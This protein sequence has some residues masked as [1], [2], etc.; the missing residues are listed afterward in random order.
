MLALVRKTEDC[1]LWQGRINDSG[2]GTYGKDLAHRALYVELV[3]PI[4][5][6]TLDHACQVNSCVNPDH[7]TP[8]SQ[9][10]NILRS[11][12][13]AALNARKVE[14]KRGH[15]FTEENTYTDPQGRRHCRTCQRA[16]ARRWYHRSTG[17]ST[18]GS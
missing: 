9:R 10:E 3:G 4:E 11:N 5:S 1:W 13:P 17:T 16:N 12:N 14:C 18:A 7:L 15:P 6:E 2:Y 8:A